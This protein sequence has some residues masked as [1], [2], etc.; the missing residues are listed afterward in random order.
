MQ[1]LAT[2]RVDSQTGTTISMRGPTNDVSVD[3]KT[4]EKTAPLV[5]TLTSGLT[6]WLN[7]TELAFTGTQAAINR[8]LSLLTMNAGSTYGKGTIRFAVTQD[9]GA[10]YNSKQS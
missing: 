3:L 6:T 4:A 2:V 5:V 9:E 8:A 1:L 10:A 7:T